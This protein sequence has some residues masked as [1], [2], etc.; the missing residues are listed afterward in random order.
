MV[1]VLW[2]N[3]GVAGELEQLPK[4]TTIN[5]LIQ[6]GWKLF[7]TD[8][9]ATS[10]AKGNVTAAVYYTLTKGRELVTCAL[11]DGIINCWKP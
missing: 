1:M 6:N 11:S 7:S 9:V 10:D 2:W 8:G 4:D 3:V 5:S